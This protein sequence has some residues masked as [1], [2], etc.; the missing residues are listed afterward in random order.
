MDPIRSDRSRGRRGLVFFST[1]TLVFALLLISRGANPPDRSV[2]LSPAQAAEIQESLGKRIAVFA[3]YDFDRRIQLTE[4]KASVQSDRRRFEAAWLGR[5]QELLGRFIADGTLAHLAEKIVLYQRLIRSAQGWGA[6]EQTQGPRRQEALGFAIVEAY[7]G[8]PKDSAAFQENLFRYTNRALTREARVENRLIDGHRGARDGLARFAGE[9]PARS[10]EI[11]ANAQ[12][13]VAMIST[14][15]R[16]AADQAVLSLVDKLAWKR[17]SSD[18]VEMARWAREAVTSFGWV[19]GFV[20]YGAAA[21]AGIALAMFWVGSDMT[22]AP[23]P[24]PAAVAPSLVTARPRRRVI[25]TEVTAMAQDLLI[26]SWP[27]EVAFGCDSAKEAGR[28]ARRDGFRRPMIV[29]DMNVEEL[30]LIAPIE[31]SLNGEGIRFHVFDEVKREVPD[32]TVTEL[33]DACRKNESDLLIAVGGGS[34]VD[35]AK[36]AAILLGNGGVIQDY[37]GVDR[38]RG[39]TPPLYVVPTTAGCGSE[40][41]QF[42]M[43]LDSKRRKKIEIVSRRVIPRMIVIDPL[44]TLSMP[45]NLTASCG[46]DALANCIEAYFSTWSSPLTDALALH[47]ARLISESLRAVVANGRNLEMRQNMAVAAFEAGLAFTNAQCG[48]VHALGHPVSGMFGVPQGISD[49]ILLPHVM[50]YNLNANMGRLV[51]IAEALGERVSTLSRREGAEKAIGAVKTLLS[52]VGL[53][54]TLDQVGVRRDAISELSKQASQDTFL[55]TNPSILDLEDIVMI[56]ENAF[57]DEAGS[58]ESE[59]VTVH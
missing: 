32:E 15:H 48:A 11:V 50:R 33:A 56:Y 36:G 39:A 18:Y 9:Q 12:R 25:G 16:L 51:N 49:A 57:A 3:R 1:L 24:R 41:S 34:V 21:L 17:P 31:E 38:I 35:T 6:F 10:A 54:V 23:G 19:S 2:T 55:R 14:S 45:P 47:G 22:L 52:D 28:F 59:P 13:S 40:A 44:L 8:A 26:F 30:S 46:M 29:T 20:E 7:R 27:K 42:C 58:L 37:E 5:R 4:A 43:V 53:P